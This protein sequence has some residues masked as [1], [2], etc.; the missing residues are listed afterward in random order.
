MSYIFY[1][2]FIVFYGLTDK[3]AKYSYIS[4]L[5]RSSKFSSSKPNYPNASFNFDF[6]GTSNINYANF[7]S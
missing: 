6:D 5:I 7:P 3:K 1:E 2:S 4:L